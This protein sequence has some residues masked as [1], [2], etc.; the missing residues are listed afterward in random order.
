MKFTSFQLYATVNGE[1]RFFSSTYELSLVDYD[2][3]EIQ[4]N[5]SHLLAVAV[6][7]VHCLMLVSFLVPYTV[8]FFF[9]SFCGV[10]RKG[11][12]LSNNPKC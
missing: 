9:Q 1:N 7:Y 3:L 8:T 2:F 12:K 6:V 11:T 5:F 10:S 4:C